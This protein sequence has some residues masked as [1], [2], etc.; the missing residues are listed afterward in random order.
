MNQ[1][2]SHYFDDMT[3]EGSIRIFGT[4]EIIHERVRF[5]AWALSMNDYTVSI[6]YQQQSRFQRGVWG[7]EPPRLASDGLGFESGVFES[8]QKHS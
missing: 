6:K 3:A 4:S 1:V 5:T 7:A 8:V 2:S